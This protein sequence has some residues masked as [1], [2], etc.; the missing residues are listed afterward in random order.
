MK[1]AMNKIG[2]LGLIA[3]MILIVSCSNGLK[4]SETETKKSTETIEHVMPEFDIKF[5]ETEFKVEKTENRD[6]SLG[7]ILITN[8]ILQGKDKNGPFMYFVAHNEFPKKLKELEETGPNSLNVAFQAMLTSSAVKLGGTDFEF[9]NIEY[10]GYKGMESI[11]KVF[12]GDGI[13]KS[14]V[15]K[16]NNDL[17][18]ISAGGQKINIESVDN[19]LNSF[20]LKK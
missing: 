11:C 6:P 17:F 14:R 13:I 18:M 10:E 16:I 1:K 7:N 3:F 19:F 2:Q 12:N 8:W 15:Y 9:T 4:K 5:P 20:G